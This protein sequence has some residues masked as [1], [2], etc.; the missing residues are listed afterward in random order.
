[1][2]DSNDYLRQKEEE[3]RKEAAEAFREKYDFSLEEVETFVKH[4]SNENFITLLNRYFD[5]TEKIAHEKA[6][7]IGEPLLTLTGYQEVG[8]VIN[9]LR[10]IKLDLESAVAEYQSYKEEMDNLFREVE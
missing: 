7:P 3:I 1:M 6:F 5:R 8:G 9:A 4:L 10:T 2:P